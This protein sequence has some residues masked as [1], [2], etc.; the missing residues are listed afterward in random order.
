M[1][2]AMKKLFSLALA[3]MLLV[4]VVPMGAMATEVDAVPYADQ[5]PKKDVN[6]ELYINNQYIDTRVLTIEGLDAIT[7]NANLA[8]NLVNKWDNRKFERWENNRG[9]VVTGN[10]LDYA[11]LTQPDQQGYA[12]KLYLSETVTMPDDAKTVTVQVME[13]GNHIATKYIEVTKGGLTLTESL[14]SVDG[15]KFER[16]ASDTNSNITNS[17]IDHTCPNTLFLYVTKDNSGS[18]GGNTGSTLYRCFLNYFDANSKPVRQ[19]I[20]DVKPNEVVNLG[21]DV[22]SY[23]IES[24][25]KDNGANSV[26]ITENNAT[27]SVYL[28]G[29]SSVT[30]PTGNTKFYYTVYIYDRNGK[31]IKDGATYDANPYQ[32]VTVQADNFYS[33]KVNGVQLGQGVNYFTLNQNETRVDVTTTTN[34]GN[35]PGVPGQNTVNVYFKGADKTSTVYTTTVVKGNSIGHDAVMT[36]KNAVG[37]KSGYNFAG[38][39]RNGE[40]S[41]LSSETVAYTTQTNDVTYY[42]V[43]TPKSS[44]FVND[45]YLNIFV[46]GKADVPAKSIKLNDYTIISDDVINLDEVLTVVDDYYKASN[47]NKGLQLDGLYVA[48]GNFVS[49]W[50]TDSGKSSSISGLKSMRYDSVVGINVMVTNAV[51][52]SSSNADTSN[53]KTGDDIYMTVT[54][55]G[56]SAAALCAVYYISKKR[57]VR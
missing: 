25:A 46:N 18:T 43:F 10:S 24:G 20:K 29:N 21:N 13:G 54:V 37:E 22:Q 52:K 19:D 31:L 9:E 35:N 6:V 34:S 12:L 8:S 40:G 14:V 16:W 48:K 11:W 57:A 26:V 15:Y 28:K 1:K 44:K 49:N 39:Q 47:T 27:I 5:T 50:A 30:P 17:F 7:L 55:M 56:L 4:S 36:A 41:T 32:N 3:A 45:I 51:V 42:P 2:N 38:W 53:P 33:M 23:M